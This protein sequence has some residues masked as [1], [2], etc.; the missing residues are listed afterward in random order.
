LIL[1][2]SILLDQKVQ[3]APSSNQ[4]EQAE[5]HGLGAS[6]SGQDRQI[7]ATQ[8]LTTTISTKNNSLPTHFSLIIDYNFAYH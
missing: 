8:V 7:A 4:R 6:G 3:N 2:G 5:P 1:P